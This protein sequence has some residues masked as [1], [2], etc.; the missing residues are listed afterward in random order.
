MTALVALTVLA[1]IAIE[2]SQLP[3]LLGLALPAWLALVLWRLRRGLP[4]KLVF[5][6][7]GRVR[8]VEA[9]G[10]EENV[11][12]LDWQERGPLWA[13][14]LQSGRGRLHLTGVWDTLSR[15]QRR[16][17]RLWFSVHAGGSES[18]RKTAA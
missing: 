3:R 1:A 14:S 17:L 16:A 5:F 2:L 7:D 15:S 12:V 4:L 11:Q 18:G 13:L 8:R 6:P 9:G 10:H